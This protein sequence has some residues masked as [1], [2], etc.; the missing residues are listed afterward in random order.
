M[1]RSASQ[2][3]T[4]AENG[5]PVL[6]AQHPEFELWNQNSGTFSRLRD[7]HMPYKREA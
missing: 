3:L 5:A 2:R 1:M 4:H 7:C 6:K